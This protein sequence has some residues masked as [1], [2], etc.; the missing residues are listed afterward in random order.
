MEDVG[1]FVVGGSRRVP[2]PTQAQV[3]LFTM[4]TWGLLLGVAVLHGRWRQVLALEHAQS[5]QP[6]SG[7][8]ASGGAGWRQWVKS[9]ALLLVAA[10][11]LYLL[12]PTL[13]SVVPIPA[14][15]V[16]YLLFRHRYH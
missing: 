3:H 7:A 13:L 9:A 15:G 1:I 11:S 5:S 16:A 10:V 14:G 6:A 4:V 12:L 8:P 2:Q